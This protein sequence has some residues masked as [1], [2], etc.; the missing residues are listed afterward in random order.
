MPN[1][2]RQDVRDDL[3]P[4]VLGAVSRRP[5]RTNDVVMLTGSTPNLAKWEDCPI[6]GPPC[7]TRDA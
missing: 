4:V 3:K 1:V 2:K 6:P 7:Y 5:T